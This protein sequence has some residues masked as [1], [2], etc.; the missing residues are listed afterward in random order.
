MREPAK[1]RNLAGVT[2]LVNDAHQQEQRAGIDSM[3]YHLHHGAIQTIRIERKQTEH[4][5]AHG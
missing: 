3:T 4:D 5:N 1:L 2:T